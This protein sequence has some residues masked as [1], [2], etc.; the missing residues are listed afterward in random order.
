VPSPIL[1]SFPETGEIEMNCGEDGNAGAAKSL[2]IVTD[3]GIE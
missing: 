2:R 1:T 3:A